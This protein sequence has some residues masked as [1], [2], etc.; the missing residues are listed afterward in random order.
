MQNNEKRHFL[1]GLNLPCF[2]A[3]H[4]AENFLQVYRQ[5]KSSNTDLRSA[6]AERDIA[7]EKIN[8]SRSSLLP[9][10]GLSGVYGYKE[11]WRSN[12]NLK[13]NKAIA[14]LQLR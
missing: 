3:R 2:S 5:A 6:A 13:S 1:I 8:E 10:I 7:Y 9:Q 4:E 14:S 11:G 12:T